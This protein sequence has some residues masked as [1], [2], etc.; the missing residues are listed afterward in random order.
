MRDY[1]LKHS[2]AKQR[3]LKY[4]FLPELLE[5]IEKPCNKGAS[6]IIWLLFF[7]LVSI[8]IW[9]AFFKLD[10]VVAA[11]GVVDPA[12]RILSVQPAAGGTV[13]RISVR[14][15]DWVKQGDELFTLVQ[16]GNRLELE[17]AQYGLQLMQTQKGIYEKLYAGTAPE[18][19]NVKEYGELEGIAQCIVQEEMIYQKER[20]GL[21]LQAAQS[22]NRSLSD[23]QTESYSMQRQLEILEKISSCETKIKEYET[24]IARY[25]S[26]IDNAVIKAPADGYVTQLN[27]NAAGQ[28][29]AAAQTVTGIVPSEEELLFKCYLT[30][31]DIADI[32]E[33]QKVNIKLKAYPYSDYGGIEGKITYI[34]PAAQAVEN[35]GYFYT[36]HA[37]IEK[38]G[39]NVQ[40]IPG[41][42]GTAEI[43]CGQRSVLNYFLEPVSK[44]LSGS[45][46]EK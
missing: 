42:T 7:L 32:R 2:S 43:I 6:L 44:G 16:E 25:Q 40:L 11:S 17:Q 19:I 38:K 10:I 29:V 9:A 30:D 26:A 4:D 20:E 34:S 46:K 31:Q 1:I 41:M 15:G 23:L 13:E 5:I 18:D 36:V 22:K 21:A 8:I 24:Q 39:V 35:S 14:E 45:L 27:V 33:G 37:V 3:E 28:T 12:G